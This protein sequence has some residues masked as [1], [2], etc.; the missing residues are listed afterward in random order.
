MD[1]AAAVK[2]STGL[3]KIAIP[4]RGVVSARLDAPA[5]AAKCFVFAHGAGAGMDHVFMRSVAAGLSARGIATLR[6]QFP[7][8]ETGGKRPDAPAVAHATVRAAVAYAREALPG[9]VLIAGGKS[10][11]ARMTSQ[12]QALAPLAGV[13]ALAFFGFPLHPAGMP[14]IARADHL[15]GIAVPMLF[16][17]GTKDKLADV[18]LLK[19]VVAKLGPRARLHLFP[20]ADHAFHVPARSGRSDADVMKAL[21]D[22]FAAWTW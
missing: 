16:L 4:G 11:G 18:P 1:K 6:Y 13:E 5:K 12:A 7:S 2:E 19:S 17:Q 9:T 3:R 8:M 21:L 10:F 14:S 22:T 15:A 20:E